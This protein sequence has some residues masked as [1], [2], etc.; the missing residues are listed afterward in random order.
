MSPWPTKARTL[1]RA[2][3]T[4]AGIH[5]LID[6]AQTQLI[7][8]IL[9]S[10]NADGRSM[11]VLGLTGALV[12]ADLAARSVFGAIWWL[13]LPGLALSA[14]VLLGLRRGLRLELGPAPRAFYS[15]YGDQRV[16]GRL[17]LLSDLDATLQ[18]NDQ[19]LAQ[20]ER[21]LALAVT[22]V[23][24]TIAYSTAAFVG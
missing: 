18:R 9:D 19:T 13:P 2:E 7:A 14:A 12:A 21:R 4:H 5:A 17:T 6:L 24:I 15:A 3:E 20:K 10:G 16:R 8:Q 1:D 23:A 22:V 11:G